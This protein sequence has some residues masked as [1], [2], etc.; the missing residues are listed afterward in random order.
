M[1]FSMVAVD[2]R[3]EV[4]HRLCPRQAIVLKRGRI[5]QQGTWNE[6]YSTPATPLL[7]SLL[8]PI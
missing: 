6:L 2:H 4:L 5:V 7:R 8:A 3:A 1:C